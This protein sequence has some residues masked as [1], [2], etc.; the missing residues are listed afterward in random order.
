PAAPVI[1]TRRSRSFIVVPP[2][3]AD[4][5]CNPGNEDDEDD[6]P[7][8]EG[9]AGRGPPPGPLED[10]RAEEERRRRDPERARR[11]PRRH[12]RDP[13]VPRDPHHPP[14]D[15]ADDPAPPLDGERDV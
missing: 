5:V 9:E 2:A 6:D 12:D 1:A 15:R 14:Q 13:A 4:H 7:Q 10:L 11:G 8:D 3:P